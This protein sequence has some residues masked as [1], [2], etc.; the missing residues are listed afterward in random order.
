MRGDLFYIFCQS[1]LFFVVM[2][3]LDETAAGSKIR[4][5]KHAGGHTGTQSHTP[6]AGPPGRVSS[7]AWFCCETWLMGPSVPSCPTHLPPCVAT[8]Q[9]HASRGVTFTPLF[10]SQNNIGSTTAF[11]AVPP[12]PAVPIR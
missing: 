11:P 5:H 6:V 4:G 9:P 8:Q 12:P 1:S 7:L 2:L 3:K 10:V